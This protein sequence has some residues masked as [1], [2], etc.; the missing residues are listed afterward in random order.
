MKPITVQVEAKF[1]HIITDQEE[2]KAYE[3]LSQQERDEIID[4]WKEAMS[5][6]LQ[7]EYEAENI[8]IGFTLNQEEEDNETE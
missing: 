4:R 5:E 7:N 3:S 6:N 1:T 2:L 8:E